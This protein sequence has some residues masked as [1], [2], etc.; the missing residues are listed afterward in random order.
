MSTIVIQNRPSLL[1][2]ILIGVTV[3]IVVSVIL[4]HLGYEPPISALW[5]ALKEVVPAFL[6]GVHTI[7]NAVRNARM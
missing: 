2:R 6:D 5:D 4:K 3:A 1:G 7:V